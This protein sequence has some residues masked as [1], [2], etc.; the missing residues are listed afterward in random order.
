MIRRFKIHYDN[1]MKI[2]N[3][4]NN[5]RFNS[6]QDLERLCRYKMKKKESPTNSNIIKRKTKKSKK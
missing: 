2:K 6:N 3:K 1:I 4:K 5:P